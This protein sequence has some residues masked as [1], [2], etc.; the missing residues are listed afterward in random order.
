M[1]CIF[2]NIVSGKIPGTIVYENDHLLAFKDI[3]PEAPVHLLVIPKKHIQSL[4]ELDP[5]DKEL[6][7]ELLL[8]IPQLAK[9]QGLSEDGYRVVTNIG[10]HG[11]QTVGH[12][13]FHILGGRQ[14][15]WPPG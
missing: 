11:G 4:Q 9:E 7:A 8:A 14:L 15:R 5:A 1:D 12:L 6:A 10:G 2:C 13:H 3:H